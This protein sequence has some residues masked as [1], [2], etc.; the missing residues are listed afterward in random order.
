MCMLNHM[1]SHLMC[2]TLGNNLFNFLL[3]SIVSGC[4][5]L[6]ETPSFDDNK[7]LYECKILWNI[8]LHNFMPL[9][10]F[11]FLFSCM[12][13]F[14]KIWQG[15]IKIKWFECLNF[16]PMLCDFFI[17]LIDFSFSF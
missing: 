5:K 8:S 11:S 15:F 16:E 7:L 12:F 17:L 14:Y 9:V 6:S 4:L 1:V 10:S 13:S 2:K 3:V